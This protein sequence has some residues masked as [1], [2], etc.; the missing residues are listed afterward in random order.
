MAFNEYLFERIRNVP[1]YLF[2]T[3]SCDSVTVRIYFLLWCC[4][5]VEA[6]GEQGGRE[7]CIQVDLNLSFY[8]TERVLHTSCT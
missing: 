2:W 8:P 6:A 1:G 3:K 7:I 5:E 4:E